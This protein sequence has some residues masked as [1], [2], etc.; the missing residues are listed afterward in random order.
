[1]SSTPNTEQASTSPRRRLS[2]EERYRQ[3]LDV[4]W[5]VIREEGTEALTLGH[6]AERSG[7]TKP[8]VYDHFGT[9]TG[10]LAELYR[11]F[12]ARQTALMDKALAASEPTLTSRATVIASSYVDCVLLQGGEIPGVIAALAGSPELEKIKREYEAVFI[13]K[14]RSVLAPFA[15]AIASAG[16]WAMLGAAEAL[17]YAAASGDITAVQ[18]KD[19]LFETIAAMVSRNARGGP[20]GGLAVQP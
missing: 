7:V 3:L 10:L 12:D 17:S 19:E 5:R 1:M 8:V 20:R 9:R 2:R 11:E 15:G 6:L 14:C 18:A 13:E 4:A 16:L